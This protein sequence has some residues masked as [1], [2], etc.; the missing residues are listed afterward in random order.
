M[1]KMIRADKR[2]AI[3]LVIAVLVAAFAAACGTDSGASGGNSGVARVIASERIY[4]IEEFEALRPSGV[5]TVKDY[6]VEELPAALSATQAVYNQLAYEIRL[7]A[8]H[9]DAVAE[10]VMFADSVTGEDAVVTG[11]EVMWEEGERDRRKCS[12][13]A[14]TPHSSCS[15]SARYLEYVIRG[16]MIL[17]CEGDESS[18]AF[19]NCEDLLALTDPA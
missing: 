10:G 14:Q 18:A 12:R 9:E 17:F 19:E 7:Y 1:S 8:S 4:T 2:I 13:A 5:K 11:N 16:N 3:L 15:Y 6:D